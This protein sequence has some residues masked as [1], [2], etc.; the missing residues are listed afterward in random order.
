MQN[1]EEIS[2]RKILNELMVKETQRLHY[3]KAEGDNI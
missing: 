2:S 3:L 1:P